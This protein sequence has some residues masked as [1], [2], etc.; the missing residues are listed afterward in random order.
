MA[1]VS[2]SSSGLFDRNFIL[3]TFRLSVGNQLTPRLGV[4]VTPD[5]SADKVL[6]CRCLHCYC[7]NTRCRKVYACGDCFDGNEEEG[8]RLGKVIP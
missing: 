7:R 8:G 5:T 3:T 1:Q 6:R 2:R 4:V